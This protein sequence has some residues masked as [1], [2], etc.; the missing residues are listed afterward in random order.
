MEIQLP[1]DNRAPLL[2]RRALRELDL[3]GG[4]ELDTVQLLATELVTN[5]VRHS[6]ATEERP[7]TL[8]AD[9]KAGCIRVEVKDPGP[10]F[11]PLPY[12]AESLHENGRGL[13]LV[14]QVSRRW[15]IEHCCGN[16]VWFEV[17]FPASNSGSAPP[18]VAGPS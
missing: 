9:V 8:C 1:A 18:S 2:A 15:G 4:P 12:D 11:S 6:S 14:D 3:A 13:Y 5:A 7:I 16:E 17:D 10:P